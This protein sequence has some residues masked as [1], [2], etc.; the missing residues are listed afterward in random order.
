MNLFVITG[1]PGVGKTTLLNAL[2]NKGF[3]TV[4][5]DA[6]QIIKE[7]MRVDGEGLPWKNKA[8]YSELMLRASLEIYQ[9]V[10]SK[11]S[12]E[13]VFFD[14]GILDTICYM[15]MENLP[16]TEELN[17][18]IKSCPYNRKVFILPPW[19]DIYATDNE[20]KQSWEEAVYTFEKMKETYLKYGYEIIEVPKTTVAERCNFVMNY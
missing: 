11:A 7:Q 9:R 5:E 6:R 19:K 14:R 4:P 8:Y 13:I 10:V 12:S 15:E 16:I 3:I 17:T 18:L 20:R 1:G 2:E